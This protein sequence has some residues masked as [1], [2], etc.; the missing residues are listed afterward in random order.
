MVRSVRTLVARRPV[1]LAW[2]TGGMAAG[3]TLATITIVSTGPLPGWIA[4]AAA[5]LIALLAA[6]SAHGLLCQ[7]LQGQFR[8]LATTLGVDYRGD[9]EAL[10]SRAEAIAAA[11]A[12]QE[13]RLQ[14]REAE[15]QD[16]SRRLETCRSALEAA[17][18]DGADEGA[19]SPL[20]AL[21]TASDAAASQAEAAEASAREA[22]AQGD[23]AKVVIV[24]A[25]SAVD[26][27]ADQVASAADMIEQLATQGAEI[28][29]VLEVINGIA[30]QTNL[31]ALNAAIEAAR[32]GEQGRGFAVVADEVRTL[33]TR[34]QQSTEE[35]RTMIDGL[36]G[37]TRKAAEAMSRGRDQAREGVELTEQAVEALAELA[38]SLNEI[39]GEVDAIAGACRELREAADAA[40]RNGEP[41][42]LLQERVVAALGMI[43]GTGP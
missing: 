41:T 23:R 35:I 31:L 22:D 28:G 7:R 19:G 9:P 8:R 37:G 2:L 25:M 11:R 34:T 16:L 18:A 20:E 33:A 17:L 6:L 10:C 39:H 30:E 15:C 14:A 42:R 29:T 27:L 12:E 21:R 24:E 32:A 13:Q 4:P 3:A 1:V 26:V 40:G 38:G 5:A 36:Q 43:Q